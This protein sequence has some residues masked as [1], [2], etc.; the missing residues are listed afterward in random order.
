MNKIKQKFLIKIYASVAIWLSEIAKPPKPIRSTSERTG[1]T[2]PQ[3]TSAGALNSQSKIIISY[4]AACCQCEIEA[5]KVLKTHTHTHRPS[6]LIQSHINIRN[7]R[8]YL[9]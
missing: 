5:P 1:S 2:H 4:A 8:H 7:K 3:R 6:D 9:C